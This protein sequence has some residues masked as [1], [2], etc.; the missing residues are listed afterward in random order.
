M[1]SKPTVPELHVHKLT[2]F[3]RQS[4]EKNLISTNKEITSKS[5]Q[6]KKHTIEHQFLRI[7]EQVAKGVI[8][9]TKQRLA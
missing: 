4:G 1:L 9:T 8:Q 6:K 3:R 7:T 5:F 2:S